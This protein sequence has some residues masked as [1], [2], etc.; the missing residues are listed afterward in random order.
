[1]TYFCV[2][3]TLYLTCFESFVIKMT[4]YIGITNMMELLIYRG[5]KL[6]ILSKSPNQDRVAME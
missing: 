1:M 6:N 4:I 3:D 5:A 2:L